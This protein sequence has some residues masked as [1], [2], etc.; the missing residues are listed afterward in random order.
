MNKFFLIFML[1]VAT[2][3]FAPA[4]SLD[5]AEVV[6]GTTALAMPEAQ[7][8]AEEPVAEP[9]YWKKGGIISL[10]LQQVGL[11][12]WAAGGES[13]FAVGTVL[14]AHANYEKDQIVWENRINAGYGV[15]RNGGEENRFE[16]TND[17]LRVN[18][19]YSQKF[20]E[21]VLMTSTVDFRTQ[22]DEGVKLEQVKNSGERKRVL[23]SDFMAPGYL[24]ASVGLT[25]RDEKAFNT[26]LAPFTGRFTFVFNDLLSK[27]GS[28]GVAPGEQIRSEAGISWTGIY[29]KDLIKNIKLQT[30]FNFFSNYENFPNTVVNL[31]L[32]LNMKVNN[33]ISSNINSQLIY[34]DDVTVTRNNGTRGKDV[35]LKNVINVGFTLGF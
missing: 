30:N 6:I 34:D 24:L 22:M 10:N 9:V 14:Q 1:M 23:I 13:S 4:Q 27:A 33:F 26:T 15:I 28:F 7:P 2:V 5:S 18:S 29:Q 19:K 35:Q 25:Y 3:S 17:L 8:P 12:N 31:G 16:K 20:S 32:N 21:N 11:T